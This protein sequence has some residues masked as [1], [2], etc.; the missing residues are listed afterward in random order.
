M[1]FAFVGMN[2]Y[3]LGSYEISCVRSYCS[4]AVGFNEEEDSGDFENGW[5][6]RRADPENDGTRLKVS[7]ATAGH[8]FCTPFN[9]R[10]RCS[11]YS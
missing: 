8:F 2:H 7:R 9:A 1:L 11:T 10:S 5:E 4:R 3:I 6:S